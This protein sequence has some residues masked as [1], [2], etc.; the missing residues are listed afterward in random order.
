MKI[1]AHPSSPPVPPT[2]AKEEHPEYAEH[3][4]ITVDGKEQPDLELRQLKDGV[5]LQEAQAALEADKDGLDTIG[6]EIEGVNYLLTGKGIDAD[7]MDQVQVEGQA[8]G[9]VAF[10]EQEHNTFR[11]GW[12]AGTEKANKWGLQYSVAAAPAVAMAGLAGG[13]VAVGRGM[14]AKT[15]VVESLTDGPAI[16]PKL[17][18]EAVEAMM[19][20][21]GS[22]D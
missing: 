16:T 1:G 21:F 20:L 2:P 7:V 5:S 18:H 22:D 15:H 8:A 6:L 10:V 4:K 17:M 19:T 14:T 12:K 11:E 9:T 13:A 3:F